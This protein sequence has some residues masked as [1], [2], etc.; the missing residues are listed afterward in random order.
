MRDGRDKRRISLSVNF[1]DLTH[2]LE[3]DAG[4]YEF[5]ILS[6]ILEKSRESCYEEKSGQKMFIVIYVLRPF[7]DYFTYIEPISNP[8][9]LRKTK[10]VYNFGLSE[11]NRVKQ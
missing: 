7:L 5:L 2:K 9:A 6:S 1:M 4:R 10:I 8:I 11:C 3:D